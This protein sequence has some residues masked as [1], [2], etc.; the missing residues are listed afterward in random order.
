MNIQRNQT[1]IFVI[2]PSKNENIVTQQTRIYE[3]NYFQ[4]NIPNDVAIETLI[5]R[6]CEQYI[7]NLT[8]MD[9]FFDE[10]DPSDDFFSSVDYAMQNLWNIQT[11]LNNDYS[12]DIIWGVLENNIDTR[13]I[14][15]EYFFNRNFYY[16]MDSS[17]PNQT[18]TF[19]QKMRILFRAAWIDKWQEGTSEEIWNWIQE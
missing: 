1:R 3:Q 14:I 11:V 9:Q 16:L 12:P 4:G 2:L 10:P 7:N 8:Q 13:N 18:T 19:N 17:D 15:R 5:Y 6:T